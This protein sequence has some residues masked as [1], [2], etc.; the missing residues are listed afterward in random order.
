M[1]HI[2]KCLML[3]AIIVSVLIV[4]YSSV[5]DANSQVTTPNIDNKLELSM[6]SY[7]L[8]KDE[9]IVTN[10]VTTDSKY[11]LKKMYKV[12]DE[13]ANLFSLS[14][15]TNNLEIGSSVK[16]QSTN[17]DI[18][19]QIYQVF[20]ESYPRISLHD[21]GVDSE[22]EAYQAQQLA[23]WDIAHSTKESKY[24]SELSKIESIE[25]DLGRKYANI[26]VFNK[27]KE[28][29]NMAL[30]SSKDYTENQEIPKLTIYKEQAKL[31]DLDINGKK[32]YVLGPIKY[33]LT[34]VVFNNADITVS[35]ELVE[36]LNFKIVDS[37][38]I[39]MENVKPNVEFY[40][41]FLNNPPKSIVITVNSNCKYFKPSVYEYDSNDYIASTYVN[42]NVSNNITVGM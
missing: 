12:G 34:D 20:K 31:F 2:Y 35:S 27:A 32:N 6:D 19:N 17:S 5:M 41:A 39:E 24:G 40:I 4:T 3:I 23:I 18:S 16:L 10:I 42:E 11:P 8:R 9:L 38:G 15:V 30:Q 14:Y 13:K 21:M 29:R 22:E 37:N 33:G 36:N 7:T 25:A 28:L 26:K 1:K